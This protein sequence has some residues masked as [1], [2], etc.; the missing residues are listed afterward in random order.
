MNKNKLTKLKVAL[1]KL[2]AEYSAITTEQGILYYMEEELKEGIQVYTEDENEDKH[3]A[4]SGEY[5]TE[6]LTITVSNGF[7]SNIVEKELKEYEVE[8]APVAEEVAVVEEAPVAEE[9]PIVEEVPIV[10]PQAEEE[11]IVEEAPVAEE[12]VVVDERDTKITVLETKV[13]GYEEEI[14]TL[15]ARIAELEAKPQAQSPQ[16]EFEQITKTK[17][18]GNTEIDNLGKQMSAGFLFKK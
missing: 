16:E 17:V 5:K 3:I 7:I 13:A 8:E 11:P 4:E 15:K 1:Q 18:T 12:E 14:E 10:E 2:L 9:E 6:H